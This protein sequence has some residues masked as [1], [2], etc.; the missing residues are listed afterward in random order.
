MTFSPPSAPPAPATTDRA[1]LL[2]DV[3][4]ALGDERGDAAF[5]VADVVARAGVSL[6]AFYAT[7]GGKDELLLALLGTD[8][9]IGAQL[10]AGVVDGF[11]EPAERLHA[12]IGQL[13]ALAARRDEIGYAGLLARETRRLADERPRELVA[14]LA[15]LLDGLRGLLADIGAHGDLDR[16]VQTVFSLVIDGIHDIT[17]RRADADELAAYL[18]GFVLRALAPASGGDGD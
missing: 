4:R 11:D 2:V 8:S 3:A 7:F 15:P 9:E 5:T 1:R 6:K 16:H 17:R 10:V 13:C 12:W 14:A 18:T